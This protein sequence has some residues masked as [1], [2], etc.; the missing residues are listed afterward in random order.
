MVILSEPIFPDAS[1]LHSL[2]LVLNHC[3]EE[4]FLDLGNDP[5]FYLIDDLMLN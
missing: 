1:L 5:A 3:R 4:S 2:E